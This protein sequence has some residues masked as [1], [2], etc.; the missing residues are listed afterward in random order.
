MCR[1]PEGKAVV[2]Q[3]LQMNPDLGIYPRDVLEGVFSRSME[4]HCLMQRA[5]MLELDDQYLQ[6]MKGLAC[7]QQHADCYCIFYALP[8]LMLV[9]RASLSCAYNTPNYTLFFNYHWSKLSLF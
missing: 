6:A 5:N 8:C 3:L 1:P 4:A 7:G 9:F 2:Q